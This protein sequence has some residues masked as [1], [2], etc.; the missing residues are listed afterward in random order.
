MMHRFEYR[1]VA[2]PSNVDCSYE[3]RSVGRIQLKRILGRIHGTRTKKQVR[4]VVLLYHSIGDSPWAV[5]KDSFSSQVEWL[6]RCAKMTSLD[7]L[8]GHDADDG[9]KVAITFDDGYASLHDVALPILRDV[10]AVAAVFLNTGCIGTGE[11]RYTSDASLGYYPKE[12]F[13]SWQNLRHL[14]EEGWTVGSH[15]VGHL[16]LTAV[17]EDTARRELAASKSMIEKTMALPCATFAYT[18]GKHTPGLRQLVA[19]AGYR[20]AFSGRHGPV[21]PDGDPLAVPRI[22]VSSEF[23]MSDFKS[24]VRGDWDYLG[25][26]QRMKGL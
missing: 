14:A 26:I 13:L 12:F 20:N 23:S 11:T 15:G 7:D 9:L 16:D 22:N 1:V 19:E 21:Q 6:C 25:W 18:W 8:L 3:A 10:G 2:L 17:G 5:S 24:I 4:K